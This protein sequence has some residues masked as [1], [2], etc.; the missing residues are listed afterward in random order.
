MYLFCFV[1]FWG[2]FTQTFYNITFISKLVSLRQWSPLIIGIETL[3]GIHLYNF[4]NTKLVQKSQVSLYFILVNT[5]NLI[6]LRRLCEH[7]QKQPAVNL[8]EIAVKK[9][10]TEIQ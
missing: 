3:L 2:C 8:A 7:K 9:F 5:N 6:I 4:S 10:V 1:W